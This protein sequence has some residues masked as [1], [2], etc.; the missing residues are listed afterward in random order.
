MQALQAELP[1]TLSPLAHGHAR[2]AHPFGDGC[3]GFA[4]CAS[5]HD[6]RPLHDRM[7]QRP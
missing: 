4:G 6:L 1:V 5:Q 2:Q 7:G 3:V